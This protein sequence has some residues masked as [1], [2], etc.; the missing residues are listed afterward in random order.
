MITDDMEL[1][2]IRKQFQMIK[3]VDQVL[4]FYYH[5]KICS[6]SLK[7]PETLGPEA[8]SDPTDNSQRRKSQPWKLRRVAL[9]T[10][11]AASKAAV[12]SWETEATNAKNQALSLPEQL[13]DSQSE[14]ALSLKKAKTLEAE[15]PAKIAQAVEASNKFRDLKHG[16]FACL[17]LVKPRPVWNSGLSLS[18]TL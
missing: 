7:L 16:M 12:A 14:L 8:F 5:L 17:G 3:E 2:V 15:I 4:A 1:I 10:E 18:L 11:L 13:V 9:A 6:A